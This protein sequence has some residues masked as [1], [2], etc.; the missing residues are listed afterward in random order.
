MIWIRWHLCALSPSPSLSL[1]LSLLV[2][3]TVAETMVIHGLAIQEPKSWPD[4]DPGALSERKNKREREGR[5]REREN[6]DREGGER[7]V[8][9]ERMILRGRRQRR[10]RERA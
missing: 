6:K 8:I 1:P 4:V 9:G 7:G 3:I 5:E 2:Y 10:E